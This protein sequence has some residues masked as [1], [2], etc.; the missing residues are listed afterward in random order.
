[1]PFLSSALCTDGLVARL[2]PLRR[3]GRLLQ[4]AAGIVLVPMAIAMMTGQRSAFSYWLLD[5]FPALAEMGDRRG[6]GVARVHDRFGDP[7][8]VKWPDQRPS[9]RGA[10]NVRSSAP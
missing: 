9:S 8:N 1:M 2:R 5:S 10:Q 7:A 6:T 3:M 4:L